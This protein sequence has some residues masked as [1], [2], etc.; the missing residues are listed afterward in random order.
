MS[1]QDVVP[2][3][4]RLPRGVTLRTLRPIARPSRREQACSIP[5]DGAAPG[6]VEGDPEL[7]LGSHCLEQNA[8]V[9][10][11]VLDELILVQEAAVPLVELVWQVPV[12]QRDQRRDARSEQVVDEL[13]VVLEACLVD[14]IIATS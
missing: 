4:P 8:R 13:D 1:D 3:D 11:K 12:K 2:N 10:F 9:V 14:G 5:E 7:D 6:L